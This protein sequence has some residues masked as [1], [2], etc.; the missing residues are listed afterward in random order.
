MVHPDYQCSPRL[1]PAVAFMIASKEYDV[2]LGT[3][4]LGRGAISGG[5]RLYEFVANRMLTS[6]ENLVFRRSF[7]EYHTG[8]RAFSGNALRMLPYKQNS[9]DFIFDNQILAQALI[10]DLDIGEIS[11]PARYRSD[12]SSISAW[13]SMIYGLGVLITAPHFLSA[14]YTRF[15]PLFLRLNKQVT[16]T[17]SKELG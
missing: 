1:I 13:R 5:M 14:K 8:F 10:A 7:P 6:I 2:V 15:K 3:R 16:I 9:D 12:S 17:R 4:M 11:C